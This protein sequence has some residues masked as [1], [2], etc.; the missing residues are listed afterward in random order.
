MVLVFKT[1]VR[2]EKEVKRLKPFLNELT[3]GREYWN[4][5]LEDCDHILRIE[6]DFLQ[7]CEVTRLLDQMN[8]FCEELEDIVIEKVV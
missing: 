4:F 5:D 3:G 1:S 2:K 7:F 6:S 8:F